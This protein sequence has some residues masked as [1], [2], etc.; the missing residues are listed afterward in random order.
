MKI[1]YVNTCIWVILCKEHMIK[2]KMIICVRDG[3]LFQIIWWIN[4]IFQSLI[5]NH[6]ILLFMIM[7]QNFP[8]KFQCKNVSLHF[9]SEISNI[10]VFFDQLITKSKKFQ[11]FKESLNQNQYIISIF[12]LATKN[13]IYQWEEQI[14]NIFDIMCELNINSNND[15]SKVYFLALIHPFAE[16]YG[17]IL[18]KNVALISWH[19][20]IFIIEV[21]IWY[22]W[23]IYQWMFR[24]GKNIMIF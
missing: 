24:I 9:V 19:L 7:F 15:N 3:K 10:V 2:L 16:D 22:I 8:M 14:Q 21:I 17:V 11:S 12:H 4:L 13:S 6:S 23:L 18:L 20:F 5:C 1:V